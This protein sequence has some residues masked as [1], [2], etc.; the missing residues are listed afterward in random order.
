MRTHYGQSNTPFF[1]NSFT[2]CMLIQFWP[3]N[4]NSKLISSLMGSLIYTN[5]TSSTPRLDILALKIVKPHKKGGCKP[6]PSP[7]PL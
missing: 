5:I 6:S 3:K 7:H 1:H 2:A 4:A